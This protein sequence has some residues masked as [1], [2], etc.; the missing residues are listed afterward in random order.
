MQ[1]DILTRAQ[2]EINLVSNLNE[3]TQIKAK[4][5]GKKSLIQQELENISKLPIE[6]RKAAGKFLN[7]I[8]ATISNLIEERKIFLSRKIL[9][10]SLSINKIDYTLKADY[11]AKGSIHPVT[12]VIEELSQIFGYYGLA[13]KEGPNVETEWYN[14]TALNIEENHPARQMHDSFYLNSPSHLLRTH[15]SPMQIRLLEKLDLPARF[16]IPGRTYRSDYDMTHTPMF[17]QLEGIIVDKNINFGHLKYLIIEAIKM[18]FAGTNIE[19]RFR[20]SF[21]PFTEPSAEVD[22]K[23]GKKDKWLEILGC[24]LIHPKLLENC[25]IDSKKYSGLAFG[26]GIER[27]AMLKYGI[28]DLRQFFEGD[29]RWLN[30]YNFNAFNIP[31]LLAGL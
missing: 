14:F 27:M 8:K 2:E 9:Q 18:F 23:I 12:Q 19:I 5:L 6:E 21:F 15:T 25:K 20:P 3:L 1:N 10:D 4:L 7:E 31:N 30:H 17:H 24:G 26:L 16:I 13:T 29:I 28:N 11:N 22:I